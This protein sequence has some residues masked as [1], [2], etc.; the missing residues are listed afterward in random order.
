MHLYEK[1]SKC[2]RLP[3]PPAR[4]RK[5]LVAVLKR[6]EFFEVLQVSL[7]RPLACKIESE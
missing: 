5:R 2:A 6:L 7:L 3:E 4:T 1:C